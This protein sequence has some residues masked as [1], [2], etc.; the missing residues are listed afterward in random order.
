[1]MPVTTENSWADLKKVDPRVI[2]RDVAPRKTMTARD[3]DDI[4]DHFER[5]AKALR[6]DSDNANCHFRDRMVAL[7]KSIAWG[8]AANLL[9]ETR[10]VGEDYG[11]KTEGA[12]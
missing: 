4:A 5:N 9:R 7:G 6:I 10:L 11:V 1:M 12:Q 3:L 8:Q 2:P